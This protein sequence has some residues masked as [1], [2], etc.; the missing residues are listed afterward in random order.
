M[1]RHLHRTS[2]HAERWN[3]RALIFSWV[4]TTL[5]MYTILIL[6]TFS[7]PRGYVLCNGGDVVDDVGDGSQS[8]RS[9]VLCESHPQP[10]LLKTLG[11]HW[12]W[13]WTQLK[14]IWIKW[15]LRESHPQVSTTQDAGPTDY[16]LV[17]YYHFYWFCLIQKRSCQ[18][19][20]WVHISAAYLYLTPTLISYLK[21]SNSTAHLVV[22]TQV[23]KSPLTMFKLTF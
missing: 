18:E 6:D 7:L 3:S 15:V 16:E 13:N 19:T 11:L 23:F 21:K 2:C 8:A 14:L 20:I 10:Q 17:A 1:E 5:Q 22:P 4:S 9:L 12:N